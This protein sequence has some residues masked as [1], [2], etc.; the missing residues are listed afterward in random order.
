MKYTRGHFFPFLYDYIYINI[1][2]YMYKRSLVLPV[3]LWHVVLFA[4]V[5]AMGHPSLWTP[6]IRYSL[7][8]SPS[9]TAVLTF[10]ILFSSFYFFI[11]F[12]LQTTGALQVK[13]ESEWEI[14][15]TQGKRERERG[16]KKKWYFRREIKREYT[17]RSETT[18]HNSSG[19]GFD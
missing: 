7:V 4:R 10:H 14:K 1:Y 13:R 18:R 15:E 19:I 5:R 2:V 11:F 12:M 17:K 6:A 3:S 16:G 9:A 8:H